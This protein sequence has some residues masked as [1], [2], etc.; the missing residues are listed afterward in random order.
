MRYGV[1]DSPISYIEI[2]FFYIFYTYVMPFMFYILFFVSYCL[3]RKGGSCIC[4]IIGH[5]SVA[6]YTY[7]FIPKKKIVAYLVMQCKNLRR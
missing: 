4:G 1:K 3:N 5:G 6:K 2:L 7:F